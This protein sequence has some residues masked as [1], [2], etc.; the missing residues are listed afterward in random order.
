MHEE[1]PRSPTAARRN[2]ARA[3]ILVVDDERAVRRYVSRVLG[4]E[5][6]AVHEAADG[7]E[8]LELVRAEPDGR[9]L[10][11]SDIVM[12]RC[13]GVELHETIAGFAATLPVILMSGYAAAELAARGIPAPA[14]C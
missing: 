1:H 4:S 5:G 13:N 9:N 14:E 6:Y 8:A 12:P 2:G 7:T 3:R 11:V 10:V